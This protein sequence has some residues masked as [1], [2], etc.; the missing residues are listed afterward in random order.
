MSDNRHG[1]KEPILICIFCSSQNL[2]THGHSL[3]LD[4]SLEKAMQRIL[5]PQI[6]RLRVKVQ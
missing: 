5:S 3:N 2:Q 6:P 4:H 1:C